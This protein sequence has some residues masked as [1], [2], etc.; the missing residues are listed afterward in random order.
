MPSD[1]LCCRQAAGARN[2]Q[3]AASAGHIPSPFRAPFSCQAPFISQHAS[4]CSCSS[5]DCLL[6]VHHAGAGAACGQPPLAGQP[7]IETMCQSCQCS[8]LS[9]SPTEPCSVCLSAIYVSLDEQIIC[10][11]EMYKTPPCHF[12]CSMRLL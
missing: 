9:V 4:R 6:P 7:P 11:K 8:V 1:C 5:A 3:A 2:T 10:H 12:H